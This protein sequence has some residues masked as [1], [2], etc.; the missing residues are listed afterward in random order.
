MKKMLKQVMAELSE[1]VRFGGAAV[2][3]LGTSADFPISAKT[4]T[5][6]I[7]FVVRAD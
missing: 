1:S 7:Q 2:P 6:Q 3:P 5:T 4:P